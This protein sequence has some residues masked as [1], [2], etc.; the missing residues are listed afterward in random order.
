ML[1]RNVTRTIYPSVEITQSTQ[2]L[3]ANTTAFVLTT[4]EFLYV[5]FQ[6]RFASRYFKMGTA[7]TNSANLTV[8]YYNQQNT[9][10][11]VEDLVD[12]TNGFTQDGFI[13]WQNKNDWK[14][15]KQTP[16]D[17]VALYWVRISTDADLSAGTTI[18]SVINL[19]SDDEMLRIYYPELITDSRYLPDSRTDFLEQHQSAKELVVLRLKQRK[20][21]SREGQ[22][23]D[24]NEVAQAAVHATAYLILNPIATNDTTREMADRA[25]QNFQLEIKETNLSI[26]QSGDGVVSEA[27]RRDISSTFVAR[28]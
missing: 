25:F 22:I 14:A 13:N 17:D 7:N 8:E 27:E 11:E 3:S 5:G 4:A 26:D 18:Q 2:D 19:Y 12:Q 16:I 28:R 9:W 21:I 6:D 1:L 24:I 15:F 23:I 20:L 10:A